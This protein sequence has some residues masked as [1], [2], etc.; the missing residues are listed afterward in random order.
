MTGDLLECTPG[1]AG[2]NEPICLQKPFRISDVLA[3][4]RDVLADA[5][6]EARSIN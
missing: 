5:P 3:L 6:A 4:L 2:G 1:A